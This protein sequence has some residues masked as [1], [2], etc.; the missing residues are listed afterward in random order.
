MRTVT[1]G[2]SISV[3][4]RS[5]VMVA[6]LGGVAVGV[7][8]SGE[9]EP[10]EQDELD[11][12]QGETGCDGEC[13]DT[14]RSIEHCGECGNSC[15]WDVD[16]AEPV[17]TP[18]GCA[19]ECENENK[20]VC[21]GDCVGTSIDDE[22]CGECS[23]RC[24]TDVEGSQSSC[25]A[26]SCETECED[27]AETICDDVCVG[28][29]SHEDH[30]GECGHSCRPSEVCNDGECELRE[31]TIETIDEATSDDEVVGTAADIT[32]D[33]SDEPHIG[34]INQT[35]GELGYLQRE[36]GQ[37][38]AETVVANDIGIGARFTIALG[39]AGYPH[40]GFTI[41]FENEDGW[42]GDKV[43]AARSSTD[44][45]G[46]E[47]EQ[48]VDVRTA[49]PARGFGPDILVDDEH[50]VHVVYR[51]RDAL[52][53]RHVVG[54][55]GNWEIET[56]GTQTSWSYRDH[57][58]EDNEGEFRVFYGTGPG[59]L[60]S[61]IGTTHELMQASLQ[62]GGWSVDSVTDDMPS[63][64]YRSVELDNDG[65]YH[66]TFTNTMMNERLDYLTYDGADW[67]V[68]AVAAEEEEARGWGSSIAVDDQGIPHV[69]YHDTFRIIYARK[70]DG[71][72]E[73]NPIEGTAGISDT[74]TRIAVDDDRIP[75]I[76][77]RSGDNEQLQ[78]STIEID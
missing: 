75:H 29:T 47:V 66:A 4:A 37:W 57:L 34:Y 32:L 31:F 40:F 36:D 8:C 9:V 53:V 38:K 18:E 56:I 70:I 50:D 62:D 51:D 17:C 33:G 6:V 58:F 39:N 12:K 1:S 21:D 72:W 48:L 19:V 30:C 69:A 46:W 61:T 26:G 7:G 54:Q 76:T 28:L 74:T 23:N 11:C 43:M 71:I 22:H 10:P 59:G 13:V 52:E 55:W 44:S 45:G 20:T 49:Q 41:P 27:D 67:M 63:H 65:N 64:S 25:E 68:E 77:F 78:Y 42:E 5:A 35:A 73:L 60:D 16:G 24:S 14:T 15:E 3:I 2:T